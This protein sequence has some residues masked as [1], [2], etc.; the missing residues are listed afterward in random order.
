VTKAGLRPLVEK[1]PRRTIAFIVFVLAFVVRALWTLRVQSPFGA[2]YSDM[3]GYVSRADMLLNGVTP[4][5]PRILALWPWGTHAVVALE[6]AVFGRHGATGI[7][8]AHAVVGALVAP[9]ATLLTARFVRSKAAIAIAGVVAA[10]WHP[11]LVYSGFFSSELW[12]ST[13]MML[14][15][16]FFVRYCEGRGGALPV[17]LLFAFAFV[18]R[19]QIVLTALMIGGVLVLTWRR[20]ASWRPRR[21][22]VLLV[23]PFVLAA[24]FSSVRLHRLTG[25]V[26]LINLYEQAQRLFGET[27]V[28]KLEAA[29]KAPNGDD[30]TW[31]ASPHTKQPVHPEHTVHIDGFIADPVKLSAIRAER[32]RGVPWT[33]RV[34][35]TLDNVAL[36]VVRNNTWPEN[37]FRRVRFRAELQYVYR[38]LLT[39]LL[40]LGAVGLFCLRRH[41]AAALVVLANLATIIVTAAI[42]LGEARYRVPYDP[43]LIVVATV[44]GH[45]LLTRTSRLIRARFTPRSSRP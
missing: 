16:L 27:N 4:S 36:L 3:G 42:Y 26:G 19:P 1:R 20:R 34:A 33:A 13:A 39:P 43:L 17:G 5:E 35:R 41:R 8:Y 2:V 11:H 45:A 38:Q 6:F 40:L 23:L 24:M 29:W 14:G 22:V 37:D 25:R 9:A 18:N 44:G 28:E 15:A 31:W 32:L 12:F 7:A 21:G 30:W 10:L